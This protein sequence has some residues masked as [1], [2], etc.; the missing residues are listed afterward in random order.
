MNILQVDVEHFYCDYH[1]DVKRLEDV[2]EWHEYRNRTVWSTEKLLQLLEKKKV[3]ATFFV[4]GCVA[5]RFPNLVEEIEAA[6]HEIASHGYWHDLV[7]RQT[8]REF[9]DDLRESLTLLDG[10]SHDKVIG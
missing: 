3:T 8:P 1:V 2:K 6:G 9:E 4:L 5:R 10:L 7:T